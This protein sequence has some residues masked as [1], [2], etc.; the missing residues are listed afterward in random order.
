MKNL[1]LIFTPDAE[2]KYEVDRVVDG[3]TVLGNAILKAGDAPEEMGFGMLRW[4][5][6][7][8]PVEIRVYG[9]DTPE[10]GHPN[11]KEAGDFLRTLL[12]N[13]QVTAITKGVHEKYSRWLASLRTESCPDVAQAII[14]AGLGVPYF[15]GHKGFIINPGGIK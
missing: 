1:G 8:L 12:F 11:Y 4:E 13:Q 7:A 10:R 9:V 5:K 6:I 2:F 14:D 15:G 3:D